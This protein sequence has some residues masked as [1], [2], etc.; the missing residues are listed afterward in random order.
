MLTFTDVGIVRKSDVTCVK[1]TPSIRGIRFNFRNGEYF[2]VTGIKPAMYDDVV[3][4]VTYAMA[5]P[6]DSTIYVK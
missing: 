3:K 6:G 2:E 5:Y 4:D 1:F